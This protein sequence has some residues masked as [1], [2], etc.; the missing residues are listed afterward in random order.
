MG[1]SKQTDNDKV[2]VSVY[3]PTEK[4]YDEGRAPHVNR[5]T[6][7]EV[8]TDIIVQDKETGDHVHIGLGEDDE[9]IFESH[10]KR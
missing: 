4:D 3:T 2:S 1:W 7:E 5:D 6:N 8:F 10:D 9:T